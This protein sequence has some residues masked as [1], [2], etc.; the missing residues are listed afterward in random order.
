MYLSLGLPISASPLAKDNGAPAPSPLPSLA[1]LP[2]A[3]AARWHAGAGASVTSQGRVTQAD[4]LVGP[5]VTAG[6]QGL[7][8]LAMT[9]AT[10]RRFWRFS[11]SEYLDVGGGIFLGTRKMAVFAVVRGVDRVFSLGSQTGYGSGSNAANTSRAAL[12]SEK[13]TDGAYF[14]NAF[15][16]T[17]TN[18]FMVSG[19]QMCLVGASMKSSGTRLFT[20]RHAANVAAGSVQASNVQG[21]E[22]GRYAGA[23]GA[24]GSWAKFDLYELVIYDISLTDAE[25]DSVAQALA[26]HWQ[27][28]QL[29]QQIVLEGDSITAGAGLPD[30]LTNP[31]SVLASDSANLVPTDWRVSSNAVSGATVPTLIARRDDTRSWTN[32]TLPGRNVAVIEIGRNDLRDITAQQ[33]YTNVVAYLSTATTGLLQKGWEVRILSNIASGSDLQPKIETFRTLIEAPQFLTDTASGPGQAFEGKVRVIRTHLIEKAPDGTI[34]DTVGDASSSV[35]YQGDATHPSAM[36]ARL[37]LTGG[38]TPQHGVT[39]QLV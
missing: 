1:L 35:Y 11:G 5:G 13:L 27:L 3:P 8:P 4:G 36:G 34:F 7:G 9:D 18:A 30:Y 33:H 23:P 12:D 16:K 24:A 32:Q 25:A 37:R 6:A 14:L 38:D 10:G 15:R 28:P 39:W 19:A 17:T 21:G 29:T 22:I 31:V 26:D 20:N 2:V